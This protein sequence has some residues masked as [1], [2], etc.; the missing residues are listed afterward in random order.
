MSSYINQF[1]V[2][3]REYFY[4]TFFYYYI[5]R[6]IVIIALYFT[7]IK[8]VNFSI[9]ERISTQLLCFLLVFLLIFIF[10]E[11]LVIFHY[12]I[13]EKCFF[14]AANNPNLEKLNNM[15]LKFSGFII[16]SGAKIAYFY[17]FFPT[18]ICMI[19]VYF[20]Q[21]WVWLNLLFFI[22]FCKV[23]VRFL[24]T[25]VTYGSLKIG[26]YYYENAVCECDISNYYKELEV[27]LEPLP[28]PI[29][30]LQYS[31]KIYKFRP[32]TSCISKIV[33]NLLY[34]YV[35]KFRSDEI[36][37]LGL[38]KRIMPF[39]LDTR[40]FV[41]IFAFSLYNYPAFSISYFRFIKLV[42]VYNK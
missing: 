20:Y 9:Y 26:F 17:P 1:A 41:P 27:G 31:A 24:M 14:P 4:L 13:M 16:I 7:N 25:S 29:E 38:K 11:K 10:M 21:H 32:V 3:M 39:P 8:F 37:I 2:K 6:T 36:S 22:Y 19:G 15:W 40:L 34:T 35:K 30:K 18:I 5:I 28:L 33:N 23:L 42:R 12:K